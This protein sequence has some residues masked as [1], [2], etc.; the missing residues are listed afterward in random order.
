MLFALAIATNRP[1]ARAAQRVNYVA[2][3]SIERSGAREVAYGGNA[4]FSRG[5]RAQVLA[6]NG[7]SPITGPA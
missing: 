7:R 5:G 3:N 4:R 1:V 6:A 2:E